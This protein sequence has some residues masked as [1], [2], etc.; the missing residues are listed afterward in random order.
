MWFGIARGAGKE[1]VPAP[2]PRLYKLGL[3]G[4]AHPGGAL[5]APGKGR[6]PASLA[7]DSHGCSTILHFAGRL[8]PELRSSSPAS[9]S[10]R[11]PSETFCSRR[12]SGPIFDQLVQSCESHID[13]I[14][15]E[16]YRRLR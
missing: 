2:P 11:G 7:T 10:T 3:P 15:D 5:W 4:V 13:E 6:K 9:T 12:E 8:A 16:R 14:A 1:L